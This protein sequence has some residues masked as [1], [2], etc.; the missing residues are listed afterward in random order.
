MLELAISCHLLSQ[1]NPGST[2]IAKDGRRR[3][4]TDQAG[5]K[6]HECHTRRCRSN[7]QTGWIAGTGQQAESAARARAVN[8][9]A[10]ARVAERR[11]VLADDAGDLGHPHSGRADPAR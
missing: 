2:E 7:A 1:K 3:E 9:A 5:D 4:K 8:R 6:I 11:S 10:A